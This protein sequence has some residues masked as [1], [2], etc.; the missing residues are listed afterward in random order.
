VITVGVAT[1]YS[2]GESIGKPR[3]TPAGDMQ[4]NRHVRKSIYPQLHSVFQ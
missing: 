1:D 3:Q 2:T 4:V